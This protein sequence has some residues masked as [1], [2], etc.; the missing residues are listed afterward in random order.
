M[1]LNFYETIHGVKQSPYVIARAWYAL[2]STLKHGTF[3]VLHVLCSYFLSTF[4]F[5][6]FIYKKPS[7]SPARFLCGP[8]WSPARFLCGPLW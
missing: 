7:W 6:L 5:L 4:R 1:L 3:Y 2:S 8:L